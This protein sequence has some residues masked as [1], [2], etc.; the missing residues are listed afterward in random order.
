MTPTCELC[1]KSP[2]TQTLTYS[3]K[4]VV[5][6]KPVCDPCAR[7]VQLPHPFTVSPLA[8]AK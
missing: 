4:C 2:A 6:S 5:V 1:R 3:A 8:G 7:A